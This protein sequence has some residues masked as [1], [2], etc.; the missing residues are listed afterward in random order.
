[1][2]SISMLDYIITWIKR[3]CEFH[4]NLVKSLDEDFIRIQMLKNTKT[5]VLIVTFLM[6]EISYAMLVKRD[7]IVS[8]G[9]YQNVETIRD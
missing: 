9:H 5:N 2:Y 6:I 1:M 3:L 8:V 7:Y 4:P